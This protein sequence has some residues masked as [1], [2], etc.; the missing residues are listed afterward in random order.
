M[1]CDLTTV[2]SS[3]WRKRTKSAVVVYVVSELGVVDVV[4]SIDVVE[5]GSGDASSKGA[6]VG[7]DVDGPTTWS[8]VQAANTRLT[9]SRLQRILILFN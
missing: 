5:L 8:P 2:H 7:M 3:G 6:D 1:H 4:E 9:A